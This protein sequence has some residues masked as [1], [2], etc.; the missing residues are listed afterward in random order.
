METHV[1]SQPNTVGNSDISFGRPF[2]W[3]MSLLVLLA[4]VVM[5]PRLG[6]TQNEMI[7]GVVLMLVLSLQAGMVAM[8][9]EIQHKLRGK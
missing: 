7:L 3:A 9:I 5:I 8:L 1:D 6:L 2:C 4:G